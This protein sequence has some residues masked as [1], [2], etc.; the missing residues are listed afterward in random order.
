MKSEGRKVLPSVIK[1][2]K[3]ERYKP[4]SIETDL[5]NFKIDFF[6]DNTDCNKETQYQPE[7]RK[8]PSLQQLLRQRVWSLCSEQNANLRKEK[9]ESNIM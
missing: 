2:N 5:K 9:F 8:M 1:S 7:H 6:K 4:I 3:M